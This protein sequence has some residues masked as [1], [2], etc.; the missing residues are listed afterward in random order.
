MFINTLTHVHETLILHNSKS[1]LKHLYSTISCIIVSGIIGPYMHSSHHGLKFS[2]GYNMF[3]NDILE[4][5]LR[6]NGPSEHCY[7]YI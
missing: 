2:I 5:T 3:L 6:W 4:Y 1:K 7:L